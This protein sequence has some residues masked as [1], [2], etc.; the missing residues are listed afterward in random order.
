MGY[1]V[2]KRPLSKIIKF[3]AAGILVILILFPGFSAADEQA[4]FRRGGLSAGLYHNL[5]CNE[6]GEVYAW[7]DDSYGQLGIGDR[8]NE[9]IPMIVGGLSDIVEVSA[10]DFHSLALNAS[11]DVYAW[12]RN[13]FGQLGNGT[14]EAS[15]TP[16]RVD[17]IPPVRMISAG[18]SHSLALGIDGY[19]YAWGMNTQGQTGDVESET[20]HGTGETVLGARVTEPVRIAGP[21]IVSVSAGGSHSLYLNK[22]GEVFA[23]GS[24]EFG[25]LGDGTNISRSKPAKIEGL[26]SVISIS[27]GYQFNLAVT[28]TD[29]RNLYSWGSNSSG[30]LG[31]GNEYSAASAVSVPVRVDVS[32]DQDEDNDDI[33]Q[34]DA[35]YSS[36][37]ATIPSGDLNSPKEGVLVWGNNSYGQLGIGEMPSQ[38]KPVRLIGTSNGWTGDSFLP[39]QAV[40]AGG[41]HTVLLS[42][43]GF[44]GAAGRADKAQLGNVSSISS[45][46]FT[47]IRAADAIAPEWPDGI[48]L[49]ARIHD[50]SAEI[51]WEHASDNVRVT[52]YTL[53]YLD[54]KN[55]PMSAVLGRVTSFI[56]DDF[57][58]LPD[59]VIS[60]Q[61]KDKQG[62]L[63]QYPLEYIIGDPFLPDDLN[64][65]DENENTPEIENDPHVWDPKYYGSVVPLEV[66]WNVDY[67]YTDD[68][69]LPPKDNSLRNALIITASVIIFFIL[70]GLSGFKRTHKGH[71]M[72]KGLFMPASSHINNENIPEKPSEID[73][74]EGIILKDDSSNG[75]GQAHGC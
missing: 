66:P 8:M 63:S 12:G 15:Q 40:S 49:K 27:A 25:Q 13:T 4:S 14:S 9:E 47:G 18:G 3:A 2:A 72:I 23:W 61:A 36:A 34:I 29:F 59:Q 26:E 62:N 10:G 1:C 58:S 74:G 38:N 65:R 54:R 48:K 55:T 7:G 51:I 68:P 37:V 22:K 53:K 11:G 70:I 41:N 20:I 21:G 56:L 69:V 35:G 24:N 28:E 31:L 57:D 32:G 19:V 45:F 71:S 33:C 30:Q 50:D 17:G 67:I 60:L 75:D 64:D 73:V 44:V 43:K 42:V 16:V 6:S 46:V 52:G 39:F 5:L